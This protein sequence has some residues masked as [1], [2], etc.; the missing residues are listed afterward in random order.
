MRIFLSVVYSFNTS[1]SS[2]FDS[3]CFENMQGD[4]RVRKG[5]E[6]EGEK[7]ELLDDDAGLQRSG[8]VGQRRILSSCSRQQQQRPPP[9]I[10]APPIARKH[11]SGQST[12]RARGSG[13][14]R[15][16]RGLLLRAHARRVSTSPMR[17]DERSLLCRCC[18]LAAAAAAAAAA[19][20][21]RE[22]PGR[23][24][25]SCLVKERR[26]RGGAREEEERGLLSESLRLDIRKKNE[27]KKK[28][29]FSLAQ[30][31]SLEA[32]CFPREREKNRAFLALCSHPSV[33]EATERQHPCGPRPPRG[34]EET[35]R[36]SS[37]SIGGKGQQQQKQQRRRRRQ[38]LR[39]R[40]RR[41]RRR[42]HPSARRASPY[43]RAPPGASLR[44]VRLCDQRS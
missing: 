24:H 18:L 22:G 17:S 31:N 33:S 26:A 9:S 36:V 32:L 28:K 8:A 38:Q 15:Q 19:A 23:S 3:P 10:G 20:R 21:G 34:S 41:R 25:V 30:K 1:S 13:G 5:N 35:P 42:R 29:L 16:R 37:R 39:R 40:R 14:A 27:K 6:I 11:P 7:R 12:T 4:V 2:S 44:Q 43:L